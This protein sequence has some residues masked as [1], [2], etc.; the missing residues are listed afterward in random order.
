MEKMTHQSTLISAN[1]TTTT[2]VRSVQ[3]TETYKHIT[4]CQQEAISN[5]TEGMHVCHRIIA[6]VAMPPS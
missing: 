4:E 5:Y 1:T 3:T 2:V 6:A